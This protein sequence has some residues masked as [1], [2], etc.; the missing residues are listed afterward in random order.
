MLLWGEEEYYK[1]LLLKA[2]PKKVF[3]DIAEADQAITVFDK[4]VDLKALSAS[5]N[6]YP[7][8]CPTSLVVLREPKMLLNDNRSDGEKRKK[9]Q[10]ELA[11]I[12]EDIPDYCKVVC[13]TAKLDKR[14]KFY[15]RMLKAACM[16]EAKAIKVQEL[17]YWLEQQAHLYG[18]SIEYAAIALIEEYMADTET[19]PLLLLKKE[20][21]KL[22]IYAGGRKVWRKEDV[23]TIFSELP[24]VSRFALTNAIADKKVNKV[25]E[26]LAIEKKR[27][28]NVIE[29]LGI[30]AFQL[31]RLLQ[32][33]ELM[34]VGAT[35]SEITG[36]LKIHPFFAQKTI[37]QCAKFSAQQLTQG[38][39][40]ITE[41]N[42][43]LRRGG[44][45]Y[46]RLEELLI[47]LLT[48]GEAI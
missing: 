36:K 5:V 20:I 4:E 43:E 24:E 2:I 7:F 1:D 40:G 19:V 21:E 38:L 6:I 27:G 13:V 3:T 14:S 17:K 15:K 12:L 25:I 46:E 30:V 11:D 16:I 41:L 44:R 32:V 29:L 35:K 33:K 31:R 37:N 8:F 9:L 18:A 10:E 47:I 42:M 39:V 45:K 48:E 26:L 23:E 22:A 28:T 34:L